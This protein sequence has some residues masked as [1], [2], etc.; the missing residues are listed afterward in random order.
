MQ[1]GSTVDEDGIYH[2]VV[3]AVVETPPDEDCYGVIEVSEEKL[4]FIGEGELESATIQLCQQGPPADE[5]V[6]IAT[7]QPGILHS[8]SCKV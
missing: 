6:Q 7:H 2:R 4:E 8:Q 1:D 3:K 5:A